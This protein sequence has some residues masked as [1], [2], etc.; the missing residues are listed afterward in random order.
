VSDF[1]EGRKNIREGKRGRG[2]EAEGE[3]ERIVWEEEPPEMVKCVPEFTEQQW[4]PWNE[5]LV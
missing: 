1:V 2:G 5:S 4:L 3:G